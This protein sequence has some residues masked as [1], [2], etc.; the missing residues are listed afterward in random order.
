MRRHD[1]AATNASRHGAWVI[2]KPLRLLTP[3]LILRPAAARI[4]FASKANAHFTGRDLE[5]CDCVRPAIHG[6]FRIGDLLLR[7]HPSS[8]VPSLE[9]PNALSSRKLR[10]LCQADHHQRS[11]RRA[12]G[13]DL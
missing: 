1:P 3:K 7:F 13:L 11:E 9:K 12:L 4:V 2:A 10:A 8:S 5:K 6:K